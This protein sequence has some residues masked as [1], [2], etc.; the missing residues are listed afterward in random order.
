[1]YEAAKKII[2]GKNTSDGDKLEKMKAGNDKA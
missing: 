1:M 2:E